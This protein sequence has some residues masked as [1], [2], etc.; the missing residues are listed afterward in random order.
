MHRSSS[1][2]V[3]PGG[4][5]SRLIAA[6][7][8][9][10]R[11][12][13]EPGTFQTARSARTQVRSR[14]QARTG[15][16][17]GRR[18]PRPRSSP[19]SIADHLRTE[20]VVDAPGHGPLAAEAGNGNRGAF[21]PRLAQYTSWGFGQ[22]LR[23]AGCSAPCAASATATTVSTIAGLPDRG[24]T[25]AYDWPWCL[26]VD[27]SAPARWRSTHTPAGREGGDRIGA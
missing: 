25:P 7:L 11:L 22:R 16:R 10:M 21:G 1:R 8:A 4:A 27:L 18:L 23:A 2:S 24:L 5:M 13:D 6:S 15:R 12:H 17:N 19:W 14:A 3:T 26:G 20:L 9:G